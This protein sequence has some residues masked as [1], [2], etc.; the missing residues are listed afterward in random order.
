M[1]HTHA[2]SDLGASGGKPPRKADI[3][4][5]LPGARKGRRADHRAAARRG[6]PG[7]CRTRTPPPISARAAVSPREKRTFE[8]LCRVLEKA[9]V[10]TTEQRRDAVARGDV[11]H[12]RLLRSRRERR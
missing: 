1:S 5:P 4:V 7:R 10:L 6:G 8:F 9:G 3:R 11:A 12:A 2:S